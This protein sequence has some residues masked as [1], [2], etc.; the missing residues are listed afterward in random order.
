M[1]TPPADAAFRRRL[2]RNYG[3]YTI[4]FVLLV[5]ALGVLERMGMPKQWLGF[6]F[7]LLTVLVYAG[8]GVF[9]RTTDPVD[10]FNTRDACLGV[11]HGVVETVDGHWRRW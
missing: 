5:G 6:S 8:I 7:L 4:G 11:G 1:S 9:S 2:H 3:A 10:D